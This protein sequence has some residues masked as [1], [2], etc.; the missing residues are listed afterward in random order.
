MGAVDR[1]SESDAASIVVLGNKVLGGAEGREQDARLPPAA[2]PVLAE[3]ERHQP[4]RGNSVSNTW[5]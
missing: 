2:A 4:E 1:A 5:K 3:L